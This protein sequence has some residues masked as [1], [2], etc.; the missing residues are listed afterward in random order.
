MSIL[1]DEG[2]GFT[3][4]HLAAGSPAFVPPHLAGAAPA[5]GEPAFVPPHL[6]GR[7]APDAA[8]D[9][10]LP[11]P[12]PSAPV[13]TPPHLLRAPS[14]PVAMPTVADESDLRAGF[15]AAAEKANANAIG[16]LIVGVT[17]GDLP[18]PGRVLNA[19]LSTM[20]TT[21][22]ARQQL[23]LNN[24]FKKDPVEF[25]DL[26]IDF[27]TLAKIIALQTM[28][29]GALAFAP[30][31]MV[32][33]E[34][35]KEMLR[36]G[37]TPE[38]AS[39]MAKRRAAYVTERFMTPGG[40]ARTA[41]AT[42][43]QGYQL[44][45]DM[46]GGM[47]Y[48][49]A[50]DH[51]QKIETDTDAKAEQL[52]V[53][54]RL[55]VR[56]EPPDKQTLLMDPNAHLANLF[57]VPG[58][59]VEKFYRVSEER[60]RV[61]NPSVSAMPEQALRRAIWIDEH[62]DAQESVVRRSTIVDTGRVARELGL[63]VDDPEVIKQSGALLAL[64]EYREGIKRDRGTSEG[65][66]GAMAA[67]IAQAASDTWNKPLQRAAVDPGLLVADV[68]GAV[69]SVAGAGRF[70]STN[71]SRLHRIVA[72]RA[73][74]IVTTLD[75]EIARQMPAYSHAKGVHAATP[76]TAKAMAPVWERRYG[77]VEELRGALDK[78]EP[79]SLPAIREYPEVAEEYLTKRAEF[80][81]SPDGVASP[82]SAEATVRAYDAMA[83]S[84]AART[85]MHPGDFYEI[86]RQWRPV[87]SGDGI[88]VAMDA[89][90]A[91]EFARQSVPWVLDTLD[92][93]ETAAIKRAAGLATGVSEWTA[94][95]AGKVAEWVA[96]ESTA[97]RGVP[98]FI[99]DRL[100]G[101]Y[102]AFS[103]EADV[104]RAARRVFERMLGGYDEALPAARTRMAEYNAG[105]KRWDDVADMFQGRTRIDYDPAKAAGLWFN[106]AMDAIEKR[107]LKMGRHDWV[108]ALRASRTHMFSNIQDWM[109]HYGGKPFLDAINDADDA[110]MVGHQ[111]VVSAVDRYINRV[112]GELKSVLQ[113]QVGVGKV[114]EAMNETL[115][116]IGA[117][118]ERTSPGLLWPE[119]ASR[120][121]LITWFS[122]QIAD[123][124]EEIAHSLR[125]RLAGYV[126]S[127]LLALNR[128]WE[129]G[130]A[131]DVRGMWRE[132]MR[133]GSK[134]R[135]ASIEGD[136]RGAM[137]IAEDSGFWR[138]FGYG[139]EESREMVRMLR[140]VR[141]GAAGGEEAAAV[142]KALED[143]VENYGDP[144]AAG[145]LLEATYRRTGMLDEKVYEDGVGFT[146]IIDEAADIT[147]DAVPPSGGIGKREYARRKKEIQ[148]KEERLSA[149][150]E[151]YG[152]A[153]IATVPVADE[154]TAA[155]LSIPGAVE[156]ATQKFESNLLMSRMRRIG[157][158]DRLDAKTVR[159]INGIDE[160]VVKIADI[161]ERLEYLRD[162]AAGL[163]TKRPDV[164]ADVLF[165]MRLMLP[166]A[167]SDMAKAAKLAD[168]WFSREEKRLARSV[169]GEERRVLRVSEKADKIRGDLDSFVATIPERLRKYEEAVEKAERRLDFGPD[170]V[171]R[172]QG[173]RY[174]KLREKTERVSDKSHAA[175]RRLAPELERLRAEIDAD[176][177][178]LAEDWAGTAKKVIEPSGAELHPEV[179]GARD[180]LQRAHSKV[181]RELRLGTAEMD[182]LEMWKAFMS[183]S[184]RRMVGTT[185]GPWFVPG[186]IL[187]DALIMK[188]HPLHESVLAMVD[189]ARLEGR[190]FG[191][192]LT[193]P[194]PW[195]REPERMRRVNMAAQKLFQGDPAAKAAFADAVGFVSA[196]DEA[197]AQL[198][199]SILQQFDKALK[200]NR[201]TPKMVYRID[202]YLPDLS[203][204]YN[205][206][207]ITAMLELYDL[208]G[209]SGGN[210][211]RIR[212]NKG[213][214]QK[215]GK[216]MNPLLRMA[217]A[218]RKLT[219]MNAWADLTETV[220]GFSGTKWV[221]HGDLVPAVFK[222]GRMVSPPKFLERKYL[223]PKVADK[224]GGGTV[225]EL[226]EGAGREWVPMYQADLSG[227]RAKTMNI[228]GSKAAK[229]E[230]P[231]TDWLDQAVKGKVTN[232]WLGPD[233]EYWVRMPDEPRTWGPLSGSMVHQNLRDLLVMGD[234]RTMDKWAHWAAQGYLHLNRYYKLSKVAL[235]PPTVLRNPMQNLIF[236]ATMGFRS[237]AIEGA[238]EAIGHFRQF[239]DGK[240]VLDN[241]MPNSY[242]VLQRQG[243]FK[244]TFTQQEIMAGEN[245][246]EAYGAP[247]RMAAYELRQNKA[248]SKLG[249]V[250]GLPKK[251]LQLAGNAYQWIELGSKAA[252]VHGVMK[253]VASF[254]SGLARAF[255]LVRQVGGSSTRE[256]LVSVLSNKYRSPHAA[257]V[258]DDLRRV[259][260][261]GSDG[262]MLANLLEING[263]GLPKVMGFFGA[264]G[265]ALEERVLEAL[266]NPERA[267]VLQADEVLF[268]YNRVNGLT[269]FTKG[270]GSLAFSPFLAWTI[271]A[272]KL[273]AKTVAAHPIAAA[274]LMHFNASTRD[275]FWNHL[276]HDERYVLGRIIAATK[277]RRSVDL[278]WMGVEKKDG[279]WVATA[280]AKG[281]F[282]WAGGYKM[283]PEQPGL[284]QF[285]QIA[286]LAPDF[287]RPFEQG[288]IA[289]F[290]RLMG[291]RTREGDEP[292]SSDYIY[293]A[294]EALLPPFAPKLAS[295]LYHAWEGTPDPNQWYETPTFA[296]AFGKAVSPAYKTE[297]DLKTAEEVSFA[298]FARR[299]KVAINAL[300]K[301]QSRLDRRREGLLKTGGYTTGS[302]A[303]AA[304][305]ED[306][307]ALRKEAREVDAKLK[308]RERLIRGKLPMGP[309]R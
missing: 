184:T 120:D 111:G 101:I 21:D 299:A 106:H 33:S 5:A 126:K 91:A 162:R 272:A 183:T 19:T 297:I 12:E 207:F 45:G 170:D 110:I 249:A 213:Y 138:T 250:L 236:M 273:G 66:L 149:L 87:R 48:A 32:E 60:L 44:L 305:Q 241:G 187:G 119:L 37:A 176:Y 102:S 239:R 92:G 190:S 209:K 181:F 154:A 80:R 166:K 118:V 135:A 269:D 50:S 121:E 237:Q 263:S 246:I 248:G 151:K 130:V 169:T 127:D 161:Q 71:I 70:M 89:G 158:E 59:G 174:R 79:V 281:G 22:Q 133:L 155:K 276:D 285:D 36:R 225:A 293:A 295:G 168:G 175:E 252:I 264:R 182:N 41:Y 232:K 286:P 222:D 30:T 242:A 216:V 289:P 178:A 122:T 274:T 64:A 56:M 224:A 214:A 76:E 270:M 137:A 288:T 147:G 69:S 259:F 109:E 11:A 262:Q 191:D 90:D 204:K 117:E 258:F 29:A 38:Q 94:E 128:A 100:R 302:P 177:T 114:V 129:Q 159:M 186:D 61:P 26:G 2:A 134:A 144:E 247:A 43:M 16:D 268:N 203:L 97:G 54:K 192:R 136:V 125:Y 218:V 75:K 7:S 15:A 243:A 62:P 304:I 67:G 39:D 1:G 266:S 206:E 196:F 53:D 282:N 95:A 148:A 6:A 65:M 152:D 235:N 103:H 219:H 3:P 86:G 275:M 254:E 160:A 13:F 4:P 292:T 93:A 233:G 81:S 195:H 112:E 296:S 116:A 255:G 145:R 198:R 153:R 139:E 163:K 23:R 165:D 193:G 99:S 113:G 309:R 180:A 143:I 251:G 228:L 271:K 74:R 96:A 300:R 245:T 51:L 27:P 52:G 301:S 197:S 284:E 265:A 238:L 146:E 234:P 8:P 85:G 256:Q 227:L 172:R 283:S 57:S 46:T 231:V 201:V 230:G 189:R 287:T 9:D 140:S 105:A 25:A 73:G 202:Q 208:R 217:D 88:L 171:A 124:T 212:A 244:N 40:V 156:E 290:I 308:E 253:E 291:G 257:L 278:N 240:Y 277:E 173:Y 24:I 77:S 55:L 68:A 47:V 72:E 123:E 167:R 132:R 223:G 141:R 229:A 104:P 35:E 150:E 28:T 84:W 185:D 49:M 131:G 306:K 260:G 34:I 210:I 220:A 83:E 267:A 10:S 108:S 221:A 261:H 164:V 280:M 82:G 294:A 18:A 58:V 31:S 194:S 307:K 98:G 107:A 279:R 199:N 157:A 211:D 17:K 78:G 14:E 179:T 42:V 63:E 205:D 226:G 200:F 215:V 188:D 142:T 20:G 303:R 298:G 115:R